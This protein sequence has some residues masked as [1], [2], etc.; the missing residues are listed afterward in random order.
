[1]GLNLC[2]HFVTDEMTKMKMKMGVMEVY[3]SPG[4]ERPLAEEGECT[5]YPSG[6][7]VEVSRH[8]ISTRELSYSR[9]LALCVSITGVPISADGII[10][11]QPARI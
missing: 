8:R 3:R 4:Y 10:D 2:Q 11:V 6:V 5:K 1:V 7:R 9:V